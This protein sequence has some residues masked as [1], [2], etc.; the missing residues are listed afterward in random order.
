MPPSEI[1]SRYYSARWTLRLQIA[2]PA[3][4]SVH[5]RAQQ[6]RDRCRK[7][8]NS[9]EM[10]SLSLSLRWAPT[11]AWATEGAFAKISPFS[12]SEASDSDLGLVERAI[13]RID[14]PDV[15][16]E[17]GGAVPSNGISRRSRRHLRMY[18]VV[19]EARR[20]R[21]GVRHECVLAAPVAARVL[22]AYG[23]R[24]RK[25]RR[26]RGKP[27]RARHG[28]WR[29]VWRLRFRIVILCTFCMCVGDFWR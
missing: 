28:A 5:L 13:E 27:T 9:R 17:A 23:P 4:R 10:S 6:A 11:A 8:Q 21:Y 25:P 20:T 16:S 15:R 2:R 7:P 12:S 18:V 3:Y 22:G 24:P 14:A 29:A 26:P 19:G 1:A